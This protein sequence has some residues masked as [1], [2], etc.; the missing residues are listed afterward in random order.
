MKS[1]RSLAAL[2][3][4][5][6]SA[7]G[8]AP[9]EMSA[10]QLLPAALPHLAMVPAD[11]EV[12][13]DNLVSPRGL[14]FGPDG[15]LYVAEAGLGGSKP[16]FTN[17]SG[18]FC[19]GAS[20]A[21]SRLLNGVQERVAE[22]FA[23]YANVNSGRGAG[24]SGVSFSGFGKAFVTVGL[25][26]NPALRDLAPEFAG[27][28][29]LVQLSPSALAS[30]HTPHSGRRWNYVADL[31]QYEHDVNPDCGDKD[32]NPFGIAA[33][34]GSVIVADAGAN[35]LVRREPNGELSTVAVFS[36]NSSSNLHEGCPVA[37]SH[38]FV[39]T[40][41]VVGPD[42]A[43]YIGHLNGFPL[44]VNG[45]SVYRMEKG[46]TPVPFIAR[47][48]TFIVAMAFDPAGNLYVLQHTTGI[49]PNGKISSAAPGSLIRVAPDGTMT[50][51]IEGL[52]KASGLAIDPDGAVYLSTIPGKNYR[53]K[54]KVLRFVF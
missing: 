18:T 25:E 50:T 46:G 20:G 16:C 51:M 30:G 27:F 12:V 39:P 3:A 23:S 43:Y 49:L 35:S 28:G 26:D 11:G 21:V 1:F 10:P 9:T 47:K 4:I 13:M 14:A 36:N 38:D 33:D 6:L 54:G 15:G 32:S 48:F 22:G 2:A 53:E 8:D 41:I 19:Y 29:Q 37:T 44:E 52:E 31:A 45:S 7:C 42:G 17:L 5:A 34:G 24:P 40:S